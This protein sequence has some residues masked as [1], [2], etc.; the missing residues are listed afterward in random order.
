[1]GEEGK[2]YSVQVL[3]AMLTGYRLRA[4]FISNVDHGAATATTEDPITYPP[5]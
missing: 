5:K 4:L 1:M 3:D 2:G